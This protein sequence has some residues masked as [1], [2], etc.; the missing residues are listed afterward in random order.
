[1]T[2]CMVSPEFTTHAIV[3]LGIGLPMQCTA[4]IPPNCN[5]QLQTENGLLG[6]GPYPS[7]VELAD[8]DLVNAG[9]PMAS[10]LIGKET[11]T[12][13]PGSSFFGSEES[14]AMIRGCV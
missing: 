2:E 4:H 7:T 14:F 10:I 13:L 6:L 5:V 9:M 3:N 1:M 8:S 12:N 11:T